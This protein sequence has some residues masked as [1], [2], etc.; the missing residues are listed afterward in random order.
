M[1]FSLCKHTFW[2][3]RGGG[4][5]W[6]GEQVLISSAVCIPHVR[7]ICAPA[8]AVC[9]RPIASIVVVVI[10]DD[11]WENCNFVLNHVSASVFPRLYICDRLTHHHCAR[12]RARRRRRRCVCLVGN[13]ARRTR[14]L[15]EYADTAKI[16]MHSIRARV[17]RS[18]RC[19]LSNDYR[20]K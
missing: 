20:L 18:E 7:D 2:H 11:Y 14:R 1:Q 10:A 12:A 3:E 15:R 16:G 6:E 17:H 8:P 9:W 19:A 13:G 4:W 5:W